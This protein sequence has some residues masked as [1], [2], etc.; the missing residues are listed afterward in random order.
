MRARWGLYCWC[1]QVVSWALLCFEGA[2][3]G[4]SARRERIQSGAKRVWPFGLL[5]L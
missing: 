3:S 2:D 5:P 1:L 4:Y